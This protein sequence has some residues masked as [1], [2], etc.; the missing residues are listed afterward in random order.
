MNI[1]F[2]TQ[3]FATELKKL[4]QELSEPSRYKQILDEF[5]DQKQQLQNLIDNGGHHA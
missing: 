5:E 3:W 1:A 4:E 2:L